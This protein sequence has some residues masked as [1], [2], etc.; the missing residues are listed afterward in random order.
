MKLEIVSR[1]GQPTAPYTSREIMS[2]LNIREFT[3]LCFLVDEFGP[4]TMSRQCLGDG[5][6]A[7]KIFQMVKG[8]LLTKKFNVLR[9]IRQEKK[10]FV[11]LDHGCDNKWYEVPINGCTQPAKAE[12]Q[13]EKAA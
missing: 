1:N 6:G 13:G 12:V 9:V 4:E 8:R 11:R 3:H 7:S 10:I 2:A 5:T